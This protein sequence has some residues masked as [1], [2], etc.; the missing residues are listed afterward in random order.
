[1]LKS[2]TENIIKTGRKKRR[3]KRKKGE[4]ELEKEDTHSSDI[5]SVYNSRIM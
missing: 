1:M 2:H 3:K 4:E 5:T